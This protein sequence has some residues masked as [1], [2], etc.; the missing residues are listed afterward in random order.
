M[1][2]STKSKITKTNFQ[3]LQEFK[4][5]KPAVFGFLS[6][7]ECDKIRKHFMIPQRSDIELQ[8]LRDF[9]VMF[10][11]RE[12][13]D[14]RKSEFMTQMDIMSGLTSVIDNEK[15]DRGLSV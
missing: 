1:T 8:N 13:P 10:Y 11:T 5:F 2:A 4:D 7:E 12:A 9:I 14:S 3:M 15:F 6:E